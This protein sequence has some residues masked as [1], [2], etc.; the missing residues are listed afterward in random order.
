MKNQN[1]VFI[2]I[3]SALAF[4]LAPVTKAEQNL[5]G[6]PDPAHR[7]YQRTTQRLS[8]STAPTMSPGERPVHSSWCARLGKR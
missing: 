5:E 7:P 2:T 6:G 3:V 8:L 1:I 4:A